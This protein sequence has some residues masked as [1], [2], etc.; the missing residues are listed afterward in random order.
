MFCLKCR[1]VRCPTSVTRRF[2]RNAIE[3]HNMKR[4]GD[5]QRRTNHTSSSSSTR[6]TPNASK[7]G[8]LP[9]S[10]VLGPPPAERETVCLGDLLVATLGVAVFAVGV[11][12]WILSVLGTGSIAGHGSQQLA[13]L[14]TSL[15]INTTIV[16]GL[17]LYSLVWSSRDDDR[18][19]THPQADAPKPTQP[20]K[21]NPTRSERSTPRRLGD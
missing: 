20:T 15:G 6:S 7:R 14:T 13:E 4:L 12:G 21:Q 8:H 3:E 19:R 2:L 1:F 9:P 10:R 5:T 16:W 11:M 17:L 18:S